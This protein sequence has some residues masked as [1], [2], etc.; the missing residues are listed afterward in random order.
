MIKVKLKELLKQRNMTLNELSKLTN[1]NPKTLSFFQNQ[2]TE[3]VHYGTLEK[4]SRA[5]DAKLHEII[6]LSP[7]IF[8]L[9][10]YDQVIYDSGSD[11]YT[12]KLDLNSFIEYEKDLPNDAFEIGLEKIDTHSLTI[13]YYFETL[14]SRNGDKKVFINIQSID[15]PSD[16]PINFKELTLYQLKLYNNFY[17]SLA[18][19]LTTNY[20]LIDQNY[21]SIE[22]KFYINYKELYK[23]LNIENRELYSNQVRSHMLDDTFEISLINFKNSSLAENYELENWKYEIFP[24]IPLINY[25]YSFFDIEINEDSNLILYFTL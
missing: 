12:C 2:K 22:D 5:L 10:P 14:E 18:Y 25:H 16:S 15:I 21:Y 17:Y 8:N 23:S 13:N 6:E 3:S 20:F 19:T 11:S 4:I 24:N 9:V 7:I 1:I